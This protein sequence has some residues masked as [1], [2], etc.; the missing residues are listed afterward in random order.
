M[1]FRREL[2]AAIVKGEKTA[3]RRP[4]S[5]NPRSPWAVPIRSYPEGMRFTV[6]PG[7]GVPRVAECEVTARYREALGLVGAFEAREGG[8][9]SLL[10]FRD[11]WA[12]INGSFDLQMAVHVIEFRVVGDPCA[13][14]AGT[15][16]LPVQAR[17]GGRCPRCFT[18]GVEVT[19]AAR[20]LLAELEGAKP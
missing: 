2:A 15:G 6:N 18:T 8:F 5:D 1:M 13:E 9:R 19:P 11:T 12:K 4:P 16:G 14:C 7:R 17:T 20:A 3:T 10:A